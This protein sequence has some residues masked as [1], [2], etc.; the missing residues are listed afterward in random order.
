MLAKEA[1]GSIGKWRRGEFADFGFRSRRM[2]AEWWITLAVATLAILALGYLRPPV[3]VDN[4]FYDLVLRLAP[5][6]ADQRLLI[7]AIDNDSLRQL[8]RWP[9]SRDVHAD[10]L[11]QLTAAGPLVVGYDILFPEAENIE[12]D[13]ELAAALAHNGRVVLPSLIEIPGPDGAPAQRVLPVEPLQSAAARTGHALVRTDRDGVV[14]GIDRLGDGEGKR[15]FHLA[16]A[17]VA[18]VQDADAGNNNGPGSGKKPELPARH[19]QVQVLGRDLIPFA[20]PSGTYPMVG[21]AEVLAGR[22]PASLIEGRIVLVGATAP[23]LGDRFS[24][25]MS[26]S[27]ETMAGVELNANYIDSLLHGRM[28]RPVSPAV[29]LL[30]SVLPVWLLMLSMMFFG[31]RINLW[32]GMFL[33]LAVFA[34]TLLSMKLFQIWLPPAMALLAVALVFPLWGWRRLDLA[35]RYMV[36]ELRGLRAEGSFLPRSRQEL[37]GDPLQRQITLMHEAIRDVRDLRRFVAQSLDSLPDAAVVT[38]LD[39]QVRIANG[40]AVAL[41]Q[42]RLEGAAVDRPLGDLFR[43]LDRSPRLPDT[44]ADDLLARMRDWQ[45]TAATPPDLGYEIRLPDGR[46]IEVRVAFFTDAENRPLGWI[47]RFANITALRASERRRED[48]LRLLTHDMRAPQASILAVLEAES[49]KV[50]PEISRRIA[51]YAQQTLSLAND[52]VHLERAKSGRFDV[53]LFDLSDCLLDSVDDLWPLAEARGIE[54][55]TQV[56]PQPAL[57]AG[58]RALVTRSIGNL[59]GN[60]LKYSPR[61]KNVQANVRIDGGFAVVE[62][63]DHGRGIATEDL[64]R[65][66]ET[67]SRMA[68]APGAA[69]QIV[70]EGAGLGLAFVKAVVERHGGEPLVSSVEGEGSTFGFRL[71]LAPEN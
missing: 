59:L 24:T 17:V 14:R 32:F 45:P 28:L 62:I 71:P 12:A 65:L 57:V 13:R 18:L 53:K 70:H 35:S 29:W 5:P 43:S 42:D 39:C 37:T 20:G 61:H 4:L 11:D 6:A 2:L 47:A 9:W 27:L 34:T 19:G 33:W 52:F 51:R 46:S 44:R 63:I 56:P 41:F 21:F 67:F 16:E 1:G 68:P 22:V 58:D 69:G 60:A 31:P 38:D 25:P 50:P 30:F 64:P 48:A 7:V 10:V 15:D 23:G 55:E 49:E 8:G 40:A 3:R 54:M 66:F 36:A 26:A